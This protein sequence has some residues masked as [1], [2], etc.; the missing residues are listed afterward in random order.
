M[1]LAK[2]EVKLGKS[3][4]FISQAKGYLRETYTCNTPVIYRPC[5][6]GFGET[7][8]IAGLECQDLTYD[9]SPKCRGC[10]RVLI[11]RLYRPLLN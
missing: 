10:S 7:G 3:C 1:L 6:L 11:F 8:D 2:T 9:V 4:E 5:P